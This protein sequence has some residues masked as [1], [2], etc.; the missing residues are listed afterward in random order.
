MSCMACRVP[1]ACPAH[2]G[3][4]MDK[5]RAI[6][7]LAHLVRQLA[8]GYVGFLPHE[9]HPGIFT[10]ANQ[11]LSSDTRTRL[12]LIEGTLDETDAIENRLNRERKP[13]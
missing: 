13:A 1:G 11:F 12:A 7:R 5:D 10:S 8:H 3:D 6:E 2:H 4:K 9:N